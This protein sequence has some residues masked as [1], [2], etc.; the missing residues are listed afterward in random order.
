VW[1]DGTVVNALVG[2][3]AGF[4]SGS[5]LYG[6]YLPMLL[7]RVDVTKVSE[8][9]NPGTYNA[10]RYA[11]VPVGVLCLTCDLAKGYL[12]VALTKSGVHPSSLLFALVMLAP[13]AGHAFS[14]LRGFRGGK[15]VAVSFGVLLALVPQQLIVFALAAAYLLSLLL[16]SCPDER[17]TVLSFAAFAAAAALLR[18]PFAVKLGCLLIAAVVS[19]RNWAD[20]RFAELLPR[21]KA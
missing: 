1:T 15:G 6:A 7:K 20:A 5:V 9:G 11:G 2:T 17:R 19:Y 16:P 3:A 8:D 12:P 14:P 21:R 4:A 18:G 13:V 10:F